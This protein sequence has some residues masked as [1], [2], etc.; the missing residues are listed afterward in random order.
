MASKG[1]EKRQLHACVA[2]KDLADDELVE[3]LQELRAKRTGAVLDTKASF[4]AA[5]KRI[6]RVQADGNVQDDAKE[7]EMV[8]LLL[9]FMPQEFDGRMMGYVRDTKY[10]PSICRILEQIVAKRTPDEEC[11]LVHDLLQSLRDVFDSEGGREHALPDALPCLVRISLEAKDVMTRRDGVDTLLH[12]LSGCRMA[13]SRF[14]SMSDWGNTCGRLFTELLPKCGDLTTQMHLFEILIRAVKSPSHQGISLLPQGPVSYMFEKFKQQWSS[15][16]LKEDQF[17]QG[18]KKLAFRYNDTFP[19][20]KRKVHTCKAVVEFASVDASIGV[21][22]PLRSLCFHW[23]DFGPSH[24][25]LYSTEKELGITPAVEEEDSGDI[26]CS[27]YVHYSKISAME[28]DANRRTVLFHLHAALTVYPGDEKVPKHVFDHQDPNQQLVLRLGKDDLAL[29]Q[30]CIQD[31]ILCCIN[32]VRFQQ[33]HTEEKASHGKHSSTHILVIPPISKDPMAAERPKR[34]LQSILEG[35]GKDGAKSLVMRVKKEMQTSS[36]D[37][38]T[39]CIL[40]AWSDSCAVPNVNSPVERK[41]QP[42]QNT[43]EKEF[44]MP[45]PGAKPSTQRTPLTRKEKTKPKGSITAPKKRKLPANAD[46]PQATVVT[47]GKARKDG[48]KKHQSKTRPVNGAEEKMHHDVESP[49]R[50]RNGQ[51]V[52]ESKSMSKQEGNTTRKLKEHLENLRK[53]DAALAISIQ[54]KEEPIDCIQ[55][56]DQD[57]PSTVGKEQD[58][59]LAGSSDAPG[60]T[61]SH[62]IAISEDLSTSQG[63]KQKPLRALASPVILGKARKRLFAEPE[64]Q[65]P[66]TLTT[67]PKRAKAAA[68][69]DRSVFDRHKQQESKKLG[70]KA[71]ELLSETQREPS[72]V[73]GAPSQD[74]GKGFLVDPSQGDSAT[75]FKEFME[76]HRRT[77]DAEIQTLLR[78]A[79]GFIDAVLKKLESFSSSHAKQQKQWVENMIEVHAKKLTDKAMSVK[80]TKKRMQE[81]LLGQLTEYKVLAKGIPALQSETISRVQKLEEKHGNTIRTIE[82]QAR[83]R[84]SYYE[85][86]IEL[87]KAERK[88]LVH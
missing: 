60:F 20:E 63:T 55:V 30:S 23:V 59:Q 34:E 25:C 81:Q 48:R 45:H 19:V 44:T 1:V 47:A 2:G 27:I 5:V 84:L 51:E 9:K 49:Q 21:P 7:Q 86:K 12:H 6:R 70:P 53:L 78:D 16:K 75:F 10:V 35:P 31:S 52:E 76:E 88:L 29:F 54:T 40:P 14:L 82:R 18:L 50:T 56:S 43:S 33:Q 3:K 80:Q 68:Y 46:N 73:D 42:R 64:S 24:L 74:N 41:G 79:S 61:F 72:E 87:A 65:S 8:S 11:S 71:R 38:E 4:T 67:P 62:E 58:G 22:K 69:Q 57:T 15:K 85:R 66:L 77:V 37:C 32:Q 36:Q 39:K 28:V 26:E 13:K 83:G 17:R